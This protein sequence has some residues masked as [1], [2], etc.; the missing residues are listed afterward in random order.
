MTRFIDAQARAGDPVA[1][2]PS[3]HPTAEV[4]A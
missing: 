1:A 3:D 2:P 4:D